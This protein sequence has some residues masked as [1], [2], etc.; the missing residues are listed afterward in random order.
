MWETIEHKNGMTIFR[1]RDAEGRTCYAVTID[2]DGMTVE[3]SGCNRMY[4]LSA[5]RTEARRLRDCTFSD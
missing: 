4:S 2:R 5:A 3:P 1:G